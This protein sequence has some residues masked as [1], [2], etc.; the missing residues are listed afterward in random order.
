MEEAVD[1]LTYDA[2]GWVHPF[3]TKSSGMFTK[4]QCILCEE[5]KES[6]SENAQLKFNPILKNDEF[7]NEFTC[8]V[9]YMKIELDE[10]V[11]LKCMHPY[12]FT[13]I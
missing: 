9:C 7:P 11:L 3:I 13:C 5:T 10:L 1:Y 2:N 6:H 4:K 8:G 12:C